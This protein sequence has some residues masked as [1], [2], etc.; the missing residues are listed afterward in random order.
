MSI[1]FLSLALDLSIVVKSPRAV[2][3]ISSMLTLCGASKF[4][5]WNAEKGG[6]EALGQR[7]KY[8]L[9]QLLDYP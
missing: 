6:I 7:L 2:A 9:N 4:Y 8:A 3:M 1:R 5:S